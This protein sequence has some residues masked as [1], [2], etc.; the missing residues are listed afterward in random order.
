MKREDLIILILGLLL[1]AGMLITIFF[2][3]EKS[4]HGVGS[5]PGVD[6]GFRSAVVD[7]MLTSGNM[8]ARG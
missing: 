7:V 1:L 2:G 4:K 3:G 6:K 5:L 8:V